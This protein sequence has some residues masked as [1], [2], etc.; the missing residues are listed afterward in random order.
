MWGFAAE[1][2]LVPIT[3]V[4][5]PSLQPTGNVNDL[6]MAASRGNTQAGNLMTLVRHADIK[7]ME[8]RL[9]CLPCLTSCP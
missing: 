8:H 9:D 4:Q 5:V 3:E 2:V 1:A 7:L 6:A